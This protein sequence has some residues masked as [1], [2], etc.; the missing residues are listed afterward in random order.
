VQEAP[1]EEACGPQASSQSGPSEADVAPHLLAPKEAKGLFN[2]GFQSAVFKDGES[3]QGPR[4]NQMKT[5]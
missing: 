5:K 4:E 1:C 3:P 2:D